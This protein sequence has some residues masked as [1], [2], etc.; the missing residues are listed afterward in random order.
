IPKERLPE[1]ARAIVAIQRDYGNRA[2]RSRARFKYTI[3]DKGLDWFLD[4]L[5]ERLGY[6]LE[7]PRVFHFTPQ[8]DDDGWHQDSDGD[9]HCTLF[10]ENGRVADR[11]GP[12][13]MTA[14]REI[15]RI[16][17]GEFRVTP[18][19]NVVI[20]R[21]SEKNRPRIAALLDQFG[22]AG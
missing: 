17:E 18:N 14:L 12:Q 20:S 22:L 19:Q 7:P 9:W 5:A 8:A 13:L 3:D 1:V 11:Q 15:A 21:V 2:D 6:R 16:H 10:V 4:E